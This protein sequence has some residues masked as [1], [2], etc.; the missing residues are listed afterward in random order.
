MN[1]RNKPSGRLPQYIRYA[2]IPETYGFGRSS[3]RKIVKAAGAELHIGRMVLI[4][5][6]KLDDFIRNGGQVQ[7]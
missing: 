5:R 3:A 4:D 7:G 6:Q 1:L 2:D